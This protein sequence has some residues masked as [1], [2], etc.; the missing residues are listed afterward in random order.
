MSFKLKLPVFDGKADHYGLWSKEFQAFLRVHKKIDLLGIDTKEELKVKLENVDPEKQSEEHGEWRTKSQELFDLLYLAVDTD[1]KSKLVAFTDNDGIAGWHMLRDHWL[2]ESRLKATSLRKELY[3]LTISQEEDPS[4]LIEKALSIQ[5]RLRGAKQELPEEELKNLILS[6]LPSIYD[7]YVETLSLLPERSLQELKSNLRDLFLTRKIRRVEMSS[8]VQGS[9]LHVNKKVKQFKGSCFFCKRP[10]HRKADC[11]KYKA[12]KAKQSTPKHSSVVLMTDYQNSSSLE[13][14]NKKVS[15]VIDTGATHHIANDKDIFTDFRVIRREIKQAQAEDKLQIEGVGNVAGKIRFQDGT[16]KSVTLT[17][18]FYAPKISW[19]LLS[20]SQILS[21]AKLTI[22]NSRFDSVALLETS[23]GN[24][25]IFQ[26]HGLFKLS[27]VL[28][29]ASEVA[30]NVNIDIEELHKRFGHPGVNAM[31]KL[32]SVVE[33]KQNMKVTGTPQDISDC[34]ICSLSKSTRLPF[35]SVAEEKRTKQKLEVVHMDL[36]EL[37]TESRDVRFDENKTIL[38]MQTSKEEL[39]KTVSIYFDVGTDVGNQERERKLK[40][41]ITKERPQL[42]EKQKPEDETE[43]LQHSRYGRKLRKPVDY[44]K[45]DRQLKQIEER[46]AEN[47]V[48]IVNEPQSY[49]EAVQSPE[50]AQWIEAMSEELSSLKNIGTYSET[51]LPL[52]RKPISTKWIFKL[53]KGA[54]GNIQRYKARIVARGFSQIPGQDFDETFSP[55]VRSSSFRLILAIAAVKG[56]KLKHIDIKTA[57]LNSEV[58]EEIY[59]QPPEGYEEVMVSNDNSRVWKLHKSLYGLKQASRNWNQLLSQWLT[60]LGFVQSLTDPCVFIMNPELRSGYFVLLIYV[61]DIIICHESN[62]DYDD[63]LEKAKQKFKLSTAQDLA[64]YLGVRVNSSADNG[65]ISISQQA[66]IEEKL[67][68]FRMTDAVPTHTPTYSD[69]LKAAE[70]TEIRRDI[71]FRNLVGALLYA[72]RATRPDINYAIQQVSKF[73]EAPSQHHWNAAKRILR[74]LKQ[75]STAGITYSKRPDN[76]DL[77]L[78]GYTDADWAMDVDDRKSTTGYVFFLANGAVTWNSR[79]QCTVALSS[80]EAEYMAITEGAKEAIYLRKILNDLGFPQAKPTI[81]YTDSQS[82][83]TLGNNP[84]FHKRAKHISVKYHFVREAITSGEI[85]L[86][87]CKSENNVADGF[88]K[89]LSRPRFQKF[90][91]GV[92]NIEPKWGC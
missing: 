59:V 9:A 14:T 88:T 91:E 31:S 29:K 27:M 90:K 56:Y 61:D 92:L 89:P 85:I 20:M 38:D 65:S 11:F 36:T 80:M 44:W 49:D 45:V 72:A 26:E 1:S 34:E 86:T 6:K 53:K 3:S 78:S 39:R 37:Q 18:V 12:W 25:P 17:N 83:I 10:G 71:P 47:Q 32:K 15:W 58:T 55:V 60:S 22:G 7:Q 84:T 30:M 74:Y 70:A 42:T 28:P 35:R 81:I 77:T 19:N 24:I 46:E 23:G 66:Y 33:Q 73:N 51:T 50:S 75:T 63:F 48:N 21:K 5:Q 87:H 79:K 4:L 16:Y 52:G 64:W 82:A 69:R 8:T 76:E 40:E 2:S 43:H 13:T 57:F 41:V 54:D 67:E 62:A 68:Q